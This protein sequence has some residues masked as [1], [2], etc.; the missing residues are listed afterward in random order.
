MLVVLLGLTSP[1]ATA[2]QGTSENAEARVYFEEG[3]RLYEQAGRAHGTQQTTLL[4]R[5][6][7]AYVDSLRIVRSRN[8]LFNA[9]IVLGELGRNDE[10]F[11]YFG[12]YLRIEELPSAD[13]EDATRRRDALR[14]EV[15]VLQ[16]TTEPGGALLWI[17]RK[18]LAPR[19]ET[20]IELALPAGE[21]RTFVEK[22]GYNSVEGTQTVVRGETVVMELPLLPLPVE[23]VVLE[24]VPELEPVEPSRPRLRNGAIGTAAATLAT[25]GVAIGLSIRAGALNDEQAQAADE[26]RMTGDPADLQRAEDLADKTDRF[27]LTADVFWGTTIALGISSI[28]LYSLHRKKLK[29]E[30]PEVG[31]SV[32]RNG[33]FASVR[34]AFG[35]A[36]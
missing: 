21:H 13:R 32:S 3:N 7:E 31:I 6:L 5:S 26:Y 22:A 25:A 35:A 11:N 30:A 16:V 19:G 36:Q 29:R 27:N 10:S 24:P 17:D 12:E 23:P 28:V 18:D 1:S 33:G 9:A 2:A 14:S 4:R 15:A 34:M 20:P 8:A